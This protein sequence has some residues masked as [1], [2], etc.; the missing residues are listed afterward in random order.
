MSGPLHRGAP[1]HDPLPRRATLVLYAVGVLALVL[2]LGLF[3]RSRPTPPSVHPLLRGLARGEAAPTVPRLDPEDP[4]ANAAVLQ[5]ALQEIPPPG[6][7]TGAEVRCQARPR[8]FAVMLD[9]RLSRV[10]LD[11]RAVCQL[12]RLKH[13]SVSQPDVGERGVAEVAAFLVGRRLNEDVDVTRIVVPPFRYSGDTL[14]FHPA[15]L[16]PLVAGERFIGTYHTHPGGDLDQGVLSE[17]DLS[18]M[19]T[20][21]VDFAGA[22]GPLSQPSE[23]IDWLFDIVD[24]RSGGW[25]VYAHERGLLREMRERCVRGPGC[26]LNELRLGGSRFNLLARCYDERDDDL[27]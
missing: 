8:H 24:P 27:P 4:M 22:V 1:S 5:A 2:A 12:L 16:G 7:D 25:N 26:P 6:L 18:W 3:K 23:Q 21:Y 19:E 15:S 13:I 17:A 9:G 14:T 11:A 20:G 10:R